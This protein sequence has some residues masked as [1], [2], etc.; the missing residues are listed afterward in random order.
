MRAQTACSRDEPVPK[1][2][3]AT[4]TVAPAYSGRFATKSGS[5]RQAAKS[6][7]SNPVRVTRFRYTAG[8]IWSVSTLLRRSGIAVPEWRVNGSIGV[9][10]SRWSVSGE[11]GGAGEVAGHRRRGG[12]PHRDE[13]GAA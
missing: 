1:S 2:D 13:G 6:P 11:V 10:S 7:S 12:D 3:P 9:R 8:M 5:L 4:R